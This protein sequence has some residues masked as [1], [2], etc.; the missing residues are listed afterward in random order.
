[1]KKT[2]ALLCLLLCAG[3]RPASAAPPQE[4][5]DLPLFEIPAQKPGDTLAVF[6]TGDGGWAQLDRSVA[7]LLAQKGVA[8][9]GLSSLKYFWHAR[10]P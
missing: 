10:T 5:K 6:L 2:L 1:M 4:L 8:V 3:M 9:V 7:A